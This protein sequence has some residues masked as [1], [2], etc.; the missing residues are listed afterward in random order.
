MLCGEVS[1]QKVSIGEQRDGI[2]RVRLWYCLSRHT[3]VRT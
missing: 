1:I 3:G 2:R